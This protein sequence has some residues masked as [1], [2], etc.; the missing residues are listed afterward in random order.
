MAKVYKSDIGVEVANNGPII[1]YLM[2]VNDCIIFCK[3]TGSTVWNVKSIL[4]NYF[5]VFEQLVNYHKL[6][7]QLCKGIDK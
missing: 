4:E 3:A 5:N 7:V 2:F 6:M 1:S